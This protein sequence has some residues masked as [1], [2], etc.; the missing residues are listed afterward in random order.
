[1]FGFDLERVRANIQKATTEDLL[2]RI[3]VY[4]E[5][6]EPSA[7]ELIMAELHL[8]GVTP[9]AV[10]AHEQERGAVLYDPHGLSRSCSFCRKPAV[11]SGWAWHRVFGR[12]PL[13]PRRFYWC[14]E[15]GPTAE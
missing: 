10:V 9:A 1:M 5:S 15:H 12:L 3:T 14:A 7:V 2:D 11:H 6:L 13:F 8:R 4:R